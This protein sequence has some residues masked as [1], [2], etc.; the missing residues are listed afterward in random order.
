MI[1][2]QND[3]A[4][5]LVPFNCGLLFG[6]SRTVAHQSYIGLEVSLKFKRAPVTPLRNE[7]LCLLF[8]GLVSNEFQKK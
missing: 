6:L 8:R 5:E 1:T 7:L 4:S 2:D 3:S